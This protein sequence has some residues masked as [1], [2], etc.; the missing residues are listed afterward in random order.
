METWL[1]ERGT[2]QRRHVIIVNV[3]KK[4]TEHPSKYST[5]KPKGYVYGKVFVTNMLY[6]KIAIRFSNLIGFWNANSLTSLLQP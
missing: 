6:N 5:F 3:K 1:R 2:F 4:Q